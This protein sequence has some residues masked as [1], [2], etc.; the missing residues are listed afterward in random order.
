MNAFFMSSRKQKKI[1]IFK[2]QKLQSK[3][4]EI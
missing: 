3:S 2:L 4:Y 1:N